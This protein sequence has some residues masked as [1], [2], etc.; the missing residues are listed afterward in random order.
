MVKRVG[1]SRRKTRS[2]FRKNIRERGK[3]SITSYLQEF[4]PGEKVSLKVNPSIHSAMVFPRFHGRCGIVKK[5]RGECYEI[6]IK[7]IGKEKTLIVHPSH[8]KRL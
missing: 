4:K 6:L 3:I 2:K 7:D 8:L 5:K 1:G